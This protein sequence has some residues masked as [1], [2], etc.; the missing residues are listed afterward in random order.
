MGRVSKER[1]NRTHERVRVEQ[2]LEMEAVSRVTGH[3]QRTRPCPALAALTFYPPI[4]GH[5][6]ITRMLMQSMFA[7]A[8]VL[9]L[10]TI[11]P[12]GAAAAQSADTV[13]KFS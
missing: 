7:R 12:S 11:I 4:S 2:K 9:S 3:F 10:L 1:L 8:V 6:D 13:H 5:V